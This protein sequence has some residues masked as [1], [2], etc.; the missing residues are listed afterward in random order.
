MQRTQLSSHSQ[1][2][3]ITATAITAMLLPSKLT[4]GKELNERLNCDTSSQASPDG[5][6]RRRLIP[7][8]WW[9]VVGTA[10][11]DKQTKLQKTAVCSPQI[12]FGNARGPNPGLQSEWRG[13]QT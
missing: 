11:G 6:S 13:V 4:V 3:Q 12:P 2:T 5:P 1:A 9:H 10:G 8:G 7:Q